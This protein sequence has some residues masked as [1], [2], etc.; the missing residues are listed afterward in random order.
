M[1][2]YWISSSFPN[3][4]MY[5]NETLIAKHKFIS[6][7]LFNFLWWQ[8]VFG[9]IN[10]HVLGTFLKILLWGRRAEIREEQVFSATTLWA[11]GQAE[12]VGKKDNKLETLACRLQRYEGTKCHRLRSMH[13]WQSLIRMLGDEISGKIMRMKRSMLW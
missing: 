2:V 10:K 11:S 8:K 3:K 12:K 4:I 1:D 5:L 9:S 13:L 7:W 6:F